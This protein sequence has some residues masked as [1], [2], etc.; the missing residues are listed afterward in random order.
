[1]LIS[2]QSVIE[3]LRLH[4]LLQESLWKML[5]FGLLIVYVV[6]EIAFYVAINYFVSPQLQKLRKPVATE[7]PPSEF[8]QRIFS[9]MDLL[10]NYSIEQYLEGFFFQTKISDIY[11]DNLKSFLGWAICGKKFDELEVDDAARVNELLQEAKTRYPQ[12]QSIKPGFNPLVKHVAVTTGPVPHI[13]RPLL[14]YCTNLLTEVIFNQTFLTFSGFHFYEVEGLGYWLRPGSSSCSLPPLLLLHGIS[15]GWSIY[16][17]LIQVFAQDKDRTII[18]ADLDAVKVKS[19]FFFMPS[20]AQFTS[21]IK[22][23]LNRHRIGKVSIVGH[24]FGSISGAWLV[25]QC[26]EIVSHISLLD[27]VSPLLF[28]PDAATKLLYGVP[29]TWMEFLLY[30]FVA[31]EITIS[32]ALH[33]NFIWHQNILWV[34]DIPPHIG[35]VMSLAMC[36]EITNP[37]LQ[38]AYLEDCQAKRQRLA[39]TNPS[40]TVAPIHTLTWANFSH[41]KILMTTK[42]LQKFHDVV[43]SS[44]LKCLNKT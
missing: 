24:S 8:F 39:E 2:T 43:L 44:E 5:M 29:K 19:M 16:Y 12:L 32:Y 37:T 22:R 10:P 13:N 4:L 9:V 34:E 18:L 7:I 3:S 27:P 6:A 38:V 20:V 42:D 31:R 28:L 15:P 14:L 23:I 1:M 17:R 40:L 21:S 35:V 33:R 11:E 25:H 26:P 41:A 36:D 30:Y